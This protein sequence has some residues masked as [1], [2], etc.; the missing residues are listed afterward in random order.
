M[1]AAVVAGATAVVSGCSTSVGTADLTVR[2]CLADLRRVTV[3]VTGAAGRVVHESA[4]RVPGETCHDE[5]AAP[6]AVDGVFDE[7]GTY[8]VAAASPRLP[9]V[10]E[11][12][13]FDGQTVADDADAVD[14]T[15]T[16]EGLTLN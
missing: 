11:R 4:H 10:V 6:V 13:T 9:T 5:R 1:L 8:R 16:H 7:A 2:N 14:V 3:T 15:V 12:Y